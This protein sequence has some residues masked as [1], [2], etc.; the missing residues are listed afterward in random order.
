MPFAKFIF[1]TL[2]A[3]VFWAVIGFLIFAVAILVGVLVENDEYPFFSMLVGWIVGLPVFL[4]GVIT[5]IS[6]LLKNYRTRT[7]SSE[8]NNQ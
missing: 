6:T 8:G 3:A 1:K 2:F 5:S 4:A 7:Q